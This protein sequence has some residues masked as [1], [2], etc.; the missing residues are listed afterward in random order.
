MFFNGFFSTREVHDVD[1]TEYLGPNYKDGYRKIKATST[2]VSNHVSWMD[3]M[4][5]YQYYPMALSLDWG[6]KT[7]PL[8]GKMSMLID[9]I[10][11]PRG[12]TEEKRNQA[13]ECI[14][15]RQQLIEDTGEFNPLLVFAE[16]ATTNN[17][18]LLKFKRGAF[19]AEKRCKPLLM[20]WE[21]A[22]IHP[23]FD[24]IEVMVLAIM[25]WSWG[26][27]KVKIKEFP[28]FEPNEYMF[29]KYKDKGKERWEIYAWVL[30]DMMCK[31]GNLQP[32]DMS[33]KAKLQYEGHMQMNK[34]FKSPFMDQDTGENN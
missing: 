29:E 19:V 14:K 3:T 30:R 12:S 27:M 26:C 10:Y 31:A 11:L 16:G 4:C 9:S 17:T 1:Y 23:A 6:F 33:I 34:K 22:S 20:D 15:E 32:C 8:M 2:Y 28:D 18:A 24:T 7:I 21:V 13:I 25:Q 5:L